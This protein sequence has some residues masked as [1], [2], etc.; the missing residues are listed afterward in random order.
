[1]EKSGTRFRRDGDTYMP[2]EYESAWRQLQAIEICFWLF[3]TLFVVLGLPRVM[4]DSWL[5]RQSAEFQNSITFA[6][7]TS[8]IGL[9]LVALFGIAFKCPL[10]QKQFLIKSFSP[11]EAHM[12]RKRCAHCGL[13]KWSA[14]DKPTQDGD[15]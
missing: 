9:G 8:V 3:L 6:W 15:H 4:A 12:L 5:E 10:C 1:M 11:F 14:G 2:K 13:S 7:L